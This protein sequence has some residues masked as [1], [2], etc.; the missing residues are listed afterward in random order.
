MLQH[1]DCQSVDLE[2]MTSP[3]IQA[4]IFSPNKKPDIKL[5]QTVDTPTRPPPDSTASDLE[6][7][8]AANNGDAS[9]PRSSVL[10]SQGD[11]YGQPNVHL[12]PDMSPGYWPPHAWQQRVVL[13]MRGHHHLF[14][15]RAEG[16]DLVLN[17][18]FEGLVS[19]DVLM[20]KFSDHANED[21]TWSYE[22]VILDATKERKAKCLAEVKSTKCEWLPHLIAVFKSAAGSRDSE[23]SLKHSG[24]D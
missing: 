1:P 15:T 22:D 14:F 21:G 8:A 11:Y 17:E 7:Q 3:P 10:Y 24:S 9:K 18:H 13:K 23:L 5:L 6:R 19:G 16:P 12:L 20:L 2:Q 4:I